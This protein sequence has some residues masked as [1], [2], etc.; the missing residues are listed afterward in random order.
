MTMALKLE[1]FSSRCQLCIE[2][3]D[4]EGMAWMKLADEH[5]QASH[6]YGSLIYLKLHFILEVVC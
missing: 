1:R 5:I 6:T 3:A 4:S 2:A